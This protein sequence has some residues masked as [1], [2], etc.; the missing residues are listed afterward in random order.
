MKTTVGSW[1]RVG[2]GRAMAMRV[3]PDGAVVLTMARFEAADV[4]TACDDDGAPSTSRPEP[5]E[6][7]DGAVR[8]V[9]RQ[10]HPKTH[11]THARSV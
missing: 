7:H 5:G 6:V 4:G 9:A 3:L 11:G 2:E 8:A 1:S 10:S